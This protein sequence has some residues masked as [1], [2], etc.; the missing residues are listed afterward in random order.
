MTS[1]PERIM[2]SP[3]SH[4]VRVAGSCTWDKSWRRSW[5]ALTNF[6]GWPMWVEIL[7]RAADTWSALAAGG[8][9]AVA[10]VAA[11]SPSPCPLSCPSATRGSSTR[12]PA[13][14]TM[15]TSNYKERDATKISFGSTWDRGSGLRSPGASPLV[16]CRLEPFSLPSSSFSVSSCGSAEAEGGG[17]FPNN[18]NISSS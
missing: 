12:V 6:L 4:C 11:A 5:E 13:S 16:F 10:A 3:A 15:K 8:A 1:P 14:A 18:D 7:A 2:V 17:R 9:P